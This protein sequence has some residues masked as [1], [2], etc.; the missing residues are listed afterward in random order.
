[1]NSFWK[2]LKDHFVPSGDNVYRPHILRKPWLIF[3]LAMAFTAEGVFMVD[4]LARQLRVSF[5][6]HH[7]AY[8]QREDGSQLAI[9]DVVPRDLVTRLP[10]VE[11][12]LEANVADYGVLEIEAIGLGQYDPIEVYGAAR[13]RH[14]ILVRDSEFTIKW[15]QPFPDKPGK[16]RTLHLPAAIPEPADVLQSM[17]EEV[18]PLGPILVVVECP[19]SADQLR[20]A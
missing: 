2:K 14:C 15:R 3:F 9:L 5:D 13:T 7:A 17:S 16:W 18:G 19:V 12:V 1:M 4:L 11:K 10:C 8:G 6:M 20:S